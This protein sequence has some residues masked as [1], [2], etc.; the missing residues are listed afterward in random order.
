MYSFQIL[1]LSE[2]DRLQQS[3]WK[4][5]FVFLLTEGGKI[6]FPGLRLFS[7]R[8]VRCLT[9]VEAFALRVADL[10][11]VAPLLSRFLRNPRVQ[12]AI[13]YINMQFLWRI[14][15]HAASSSLPCYNDLK[16][17]D[18]FYHTG[19]YQW[20]LVPMYDINGTT[21][22]TN[23]YILVLVYGPVVQ[24]TVLLGMNHFF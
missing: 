10:E 22:G 8:T 1:I 3:Y 24:L 5:A 11:D 18:K 17:P 12:G 23:M 16:L 9:N 4:R 6:R 21:G 7:T 15:H 19:I 20:I 2:R 13:R 14:E